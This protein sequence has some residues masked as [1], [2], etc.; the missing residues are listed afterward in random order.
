MVTSRHGNCARVAAVSR[1]ATTSTASSNRSP[2][3]YDAARV[4]N[5]TVVCG[6]AVSTL[7]FTISVPIRA[8]DFQW[9]SRMSSPRTYSR[10]AW[11][12]IEPRGALS[13]VGPS[14]CRARPDAAR[15]RVCTFGWTNTVRTCSTS[16]RRR[17]SPNGSLRSQRSGPT[18]ST[19]RRSVGRR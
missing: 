2:S 14:R 19:P 10:S 16:W 18:V 6:I 1:L 4:S 3:S 15:S 9:M 8:D 17:H 13:D 7:S 12:V 11:N 5:S